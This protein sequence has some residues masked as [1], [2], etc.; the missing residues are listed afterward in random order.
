VT[1]ECAAPANGIAVALASSN[2]AVAA[3]T[4]SRITIPA[5]SASG[6]FTV[7][8]TDVSASGSAIIKATANS[9]TKSRTLTVN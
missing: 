3:P 1:L 4:A 6:K 5:G 2:T 9:I 7:R 8:T